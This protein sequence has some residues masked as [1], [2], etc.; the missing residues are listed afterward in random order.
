MFIRTHEIIDEL[1]SL[2]IPEILEE[3]EFLFFKFY[4][5]THFFSLFLFFKIITAMLNRR[6]RHHTIKQI[7]SHDLPTNV[8]LL[9]VVSCSLRLCVHD[10]LNCYENDT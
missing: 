7:V 2:T 10:W 5:F 6:D 9:V 4:L 1:D 3:K 8:G